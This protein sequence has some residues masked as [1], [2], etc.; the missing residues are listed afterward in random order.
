MSVVLS[1]AEH[2]AADLVGT[3]HWIAGDMAAL[4]RTLKALPWLP[5]SIRDIRAFRIEEWSD[6]TPVIKGQ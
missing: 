6:L 4:S 2:D 3:L 1:Q 5:S